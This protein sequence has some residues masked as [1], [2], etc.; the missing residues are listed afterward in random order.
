MNTISR[1]IAVVLLLPASITAQQLC[2]ECS[3]SLG[4]G[5]MFTPPANGSGDQ[6]VASAIGFYSA[7]QNVADDG[8]VLITG[9]MPVCVMPIVGLGKDISICSDSTLIVRSNAFLAFTKWEATPDD[10]NITPSDS[11]TDSIVVKQNVGEIKRIRFKVY[12]SKGG[13]HSSETQST[14]SV[15][16]KIKPVLSND[17]MISDTTRVCNN[18][19]FIVDISDSYYDIDSLDFLWDDGETSPQRT[20][21]LTNSPVNRKLSI[22]IKGQANLCD[23]V[24]NMIFAPIAPR[25]STS[26]QP[27]DGISVL[28]PADY[29]NL[30]NPFYFDVKL[31]DINQGFDQAF[32]LCPPSKVKAEI[33]IPRKLF[34]PTGSGYTKIS[35]TESTATL[36]Y[37]HAISDAKADNVLFKIEGIPILIDDTLG[38]LSISRLLLIDEDG[39][40]TV[41]DI[42]AGSTIDLKLKTCDIDGV[43]RLLNNYLLKYVGIIYPNPAQSAITLQLNN[44]NSY[45]EEEGSKH[46]FLKLYTSTGIQVF[47]HEYAYETMPERLTIP[48]PESLAS[49]TYSLVIYN[50]QASSIKTVVINK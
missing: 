45:T 5:F 3:S 47:T 25:A 36:Q 29:E 23:T 2:K 32:R 43:A 12:A 9:Y 17:V 16:P 26:I 49:G 21:R 38:T 50:N 1:L 22:S 40:S 24:L 35:E 27:K 6:I 18:K 15:Y 37:E 46:L 8:S 48:L 33:S 10:F 34:F 41:Y 13:I 19:D 31:S 4:S 28:N 39:D 7:P 11:L 14:V 20:F 42:V 30:D 44:T